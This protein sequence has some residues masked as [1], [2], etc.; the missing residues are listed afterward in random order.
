MEQM[1][2]QVLL[3]KSEKLTVSLI[4]SLMTKIQVIL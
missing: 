1:V 3:L 4:G 2:N